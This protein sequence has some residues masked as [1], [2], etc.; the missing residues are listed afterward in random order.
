[1]FGR[2]DFW[3]GLAVGVVAGAFGYKLMNE[4]YSR[5]AV[6]GAPMPPA[7]GVGEPP[8]EEL[9]RQKEHLDDLIAEKQAAAQ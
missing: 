8:L 6:P 7:S 1:M 9:M 2:S 5:C 3:I 4:H